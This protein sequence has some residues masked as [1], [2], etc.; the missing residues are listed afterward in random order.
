MD[1]WDLMIDTTRVKNR[2]QPAVGG[3]IPGQ[4]EGDESD[5]RESNGSDTSILL[6]A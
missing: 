1:L 3:T 4:D 2:D 5:A 6:A